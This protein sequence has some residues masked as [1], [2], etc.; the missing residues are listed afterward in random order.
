MITN[1]PD[2]LIAQSDKVINLLRFYKGIDRSEIS[3]KLQVSMPT[4]YN[5]VDTLT[6]C[7]VLDKNKTTVSVNS[8]F[9]TLVGISIG[10]SLCKV[11]FIDF[12]LD[13]FSL[14]SFNPHKQK[15]CDEISKFLKENN[16]NTDLL[17]KCQNDSSKNYIY[18]K[19]PSSF[20]SLKNVLN[21]IF[22]HLVSCTILNTLN[23]LSIGISCTGIINGKTETILNSH[24]LLY[25]NNATLDSLILPDKRIFFNKNG[26]YVCI[27]QNSNASVIAEKI[28]LYKTN[29]PYKN[30][31]NIISLYLGV[32]L[33]AGIYVGQL[34]TGSSGYAG[35][36]SHSRA[37][38][39]ESDEDI[40]KHELLLENNK[41]DDRCA[42]GSKDCYDYK[43]RSFVFEKRALEFCDMSS[44]DIRIYLTKNPE[45][46]KLFSEYLGNI[47]NLITSFL[48]IDL[49][50]FTGKFYKSMDLLI[51]EIDKVQDQ[52]PM[53]FSRNDCKIITSELGA[54][55]PSVGAA[56]YS[57]HKKYDLDLS[58]NY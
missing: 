25:L 55:A 24:N 8:Q 27:T 43:I 56:I 34:Y 45:K 41:V 38:K 19:T 9:A 51:N 57:Y 37:I 15:I 36:I 6:S 11:V 42:C 50:I 52:N 16:E 13:I 21:I 48:D 4:I 49:I 44:E 28:S 39:L 5:M 10:S 2:K 26:I 40:V 12:N 46:A 22:N 54:L 1:N 20:S 29:S 14:D 23:I 17:L 18:F 58:W 7:G 35:E 32:G 47:V 3:R 53:R 31:K 30:K 33:G